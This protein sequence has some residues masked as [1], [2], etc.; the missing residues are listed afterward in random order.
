MKSHATKPNGSTIDTKTNDDASLQ[1]VWT[2]GELMYWYVL[3]SVTVRLYIS[4]PTTKNSSPGASG[5]EITCYKAQWV[6]NRH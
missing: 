4:S 3:D 1:L 6:D 2:L 5:H